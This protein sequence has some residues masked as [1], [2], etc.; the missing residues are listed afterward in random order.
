MKKILSLA[1]LIIFTI[2]V[3]CSCTQQG[4]NSKAES[5]IHTSPNSN[6]TL[7]D[8]T[9]IKFQYFFRGFIPLK[10]NQISTYPTGTY[11]IETDKEWH[12]FMDKYVPGIPYYTS[13]D[14]SK[15]CLVFS[16]FLPA[17]PT[18]S[19]GS[20]IKA[21]IV[22]ENKLEPEFIEKIPTGDSNGIYAQ[23]IDDIVHC[24]VNIVKINK[25]DIPKGIENIYHSR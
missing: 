7:S 23:N 18:Y 25:D 4:A 12:D 11:I 16:A 5:D 6:Y 3:F 2:T 17:K 8:S 15:E 1:I 10:E 22:N 21:F 9:N 13:V 19:Y 14:Y 20:D 24:Y